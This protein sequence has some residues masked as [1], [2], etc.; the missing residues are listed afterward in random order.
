MRDSD[1]AD[2]QRL[3]EV[4]RILSLGAIRLWQE[5]AQKASKKP[6]AAG[7]KAGLIVRGGEKFAWVKRPPSGPA[8]TSLN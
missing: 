7:L 8:R 5:K 6:L 3:E 1:L 4:G 2:T